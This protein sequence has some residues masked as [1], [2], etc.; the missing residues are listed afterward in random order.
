MHYLLLMSKIQVGSGL[1]VNDALPAPN[2]QDIGWL[3]EILLKR[4]C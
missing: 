1:G 2:K 3:E 4:F